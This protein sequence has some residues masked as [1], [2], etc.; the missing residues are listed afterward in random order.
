[1]EIVQTKTGHDRL[2]TVSVSPL[3][4]ASQNIYGLSNPGQLF[5]LQERER[6]VLNIFR[7]MNRDVLRTGKILEVGC[8]SGV[9]IRDL[10]RWGANPANISGVELL[11]ERA[12]AAQRLS[13]AG[14]SIHCGDARQLHFPD[15]T[16]DVVIQST[17]FTSI[18][19]RE[20]Q[21]QLARE[22][23]RVTKPD[24][25]ILWYDFYRNNPWN[26]EV[27]GVKKSEIL[28]LFPNCD[29][30][31][32]SMTLMPPLV[33]MVAPISWISCQVLSLVPLLRT[34]YLGTIR[35]NNGHE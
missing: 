33:R 9:W 5:M 4:A 31:L 13:P 34:H 35:R 3:L 25:V 22:M 1:M 28:K 11:P 10:I 16:F 23:L 26:S 15:K 20:T 18:L 7:K 27:R 21:R 19:D 2:E 29:I 14:V 8:G 32:R 6:G 12:A 24:G 30:Q 17:V